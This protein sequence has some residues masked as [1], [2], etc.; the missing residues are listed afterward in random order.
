MK[1]SN[2]RVTQVT[3]SDLAPGEAPDIP[4]YRASIFIVPDTIMVEFDQL[5]EGDSV[6]FRSLTATG[7]S[8]RLMTSGEHKPTHRTG[9]VTWIKRTPESLH[10]LI[11]D[12]QLRQWDRV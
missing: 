11:R 9:T 2:A 10:Q 1:I 7:R 12:L 4:T 8:Y 6:G 3:A 5:P